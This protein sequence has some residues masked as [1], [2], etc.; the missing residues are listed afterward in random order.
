MIN[1]KIRN[2]GMLQTNCY[3]CYD[4]SKNCVVI[5]PGSNPEVILNLI[6]NESL[7]LVNIIL[8]HGHFDH[9]TVVKEL[10][11]AYPNVPIYLHKED[12]EMYQEARKITNQYTG[13]NFDD[14]EMPKDI[15]FMSEGD[16]INTGN[17]SFKVIH[18]PGHTQGGVCLFDEDNKILFSGDT[19][20]R[21]SVGRTDLKG[22]NT[23]QLL[24]SI[25][26][27][28][29]VLDDKI[30]VY[31]GHGEYTTV[32]CEKAYNQYLLGRV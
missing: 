19:L 28:I 32:G 5:D 7:N 13:L 6:D 25:I 27:K 31:P 17:I 8:T 14:Y 2:L 22:G 24:D 12:Y 29:F 30:T 3:I 18:T 1:I 11:D 10:K 21:L 20:F 16:I 15:K 4:E 9:V 23:E 26:K